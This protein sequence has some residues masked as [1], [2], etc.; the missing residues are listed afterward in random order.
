MGAGACGLFLAADGVGLLFAA[1]AMSG[2]AVGTATSALAATL[3]DLHPEGSRH[4]PVVTTA[5]SMLGLAAGGLGTSAL[6]QYGPAEHAAPRRS[7]QS[8][9]P[10]QA[11]MRSAESPRSAH[12]AN[13]ALR[14]ASTARD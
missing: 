4:A 11:P 9:S 13:Q 3:I 10:A 12:I 7:P 1:R 5:T 6:V 2:A 14:S 8:A